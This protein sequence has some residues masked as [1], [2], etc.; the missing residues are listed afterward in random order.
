MAMNANHTANRI[1]LFIFSLTLSLAAVGQTMQPQH[2]GEIKQAI[3]KL[4][5][6]GSVLYFAAHPDDENTRLIAWLAK[7]KQYRTGYLSLTRGDGG[8][9]LIGTEQAEELGL[10]RTNELLAARRVDG[11]EQFFSRAVDFGFSK[12]WDETFRIW[13]R[14]D[15]LADAV[16][17]IRKFRPDVIITRF[18]PDERAGHG[19]H[20]ASALLAIEAFKAAADPNRF[21][22]QLTE[23][24]IWQ[25]KRLLW[26]TG[27]FFQGSTAGSTQFLVNIGDYN[28][29]LGLSYGE[30]AAD[31]RS[32]HKSQGF[33]SA[34]QRG[35][36]VERFE[37]LQGDLPREHLFDG[38]ETSWKRVAGGEHMA[39][40]IDAIDRD[41]DMTHPERSVGSLLTLFD[42]LTKLPDSYW[43]SRKIEEVS[44]LILACG[45]IW[46]ESYAPAPKY[47]LGERIPVTTAF[48]VRRPGLNVTVNGT[49]LPFNEVQTIHDTYATDRTTQPYW[50]RQVH[51]LGRFNVTDRQEIGRPGNADLPKRLITLQINGRTLTFERPIVYKYTHPVRGEVYQPL[52]VAPR[53]TANLGQ[54]A[55]V[56]N[57]DQ[58]KSLEVTFTAHAAGRTTATASLR[59][60]SGWRAEPQQVAL[61]F[62]DRDDEQQAIFTIYPAQTAALSDS[63]AVVIHENGRAGA[64]SAFREI[65]Y[66]HIPHIAWFPPASARLS[67][68]ETG[69]SAQ[70]IGYLPGAGDLIPQALREIGLQVDMLSEQDV[71]SGNL[72]QYDAI[73]TGVRLYNVNERIRQLQPRLLAYVENGGTLVVQYN[74]NGGLKT[75]NLGPYPLTLTR[76]R[77]TD[78]AAPVTIVDPE[79]RIMTYPNRITAADFEGWIQERGLYFVGEAD[80]R[81]ERPLR[82]A[83]PGESA[84]DGSLL[85][86]RYGKGNFVYTSLA[87]FRQLPVGVPGAYRLFVNLLAKPN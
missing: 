46:F 36:V 22:E 31:S 64:A 5:V 60:P 55:L 41:F 20:Q 53:I 21:P 57:G 68:I 83:D 74:V 66:D 10:I 1:L 27:G 30:I 44:D 3:K 82:M 18:P 65:A 52:V 33:G 42:E 79:S 58:P 29:Y 47:A 48:I 87:F 4:N 56:F 70:R 19:H 14:D 62:G 59:L 49:A 54:K 39:Q 26:N 25:P 43:K 17:V 77:V 78:E 6:L 84:L 32:N 2:A 50:L 40:L 35:D 75:N 61:D 8:Q 11:G 34:R 13:G 7:E 16:W 37:L 67:K 72:S 81:Y 73:V 28:P 24:E 23:V 45:G 76:N 51:G 69:V 71:L 80:S 63:V 38:V 9:N 86:A 85:V 15:I 12:T